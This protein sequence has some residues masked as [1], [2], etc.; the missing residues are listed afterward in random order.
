[1]SERVNVFAAAESE[2]F[3]CREHDVHRKQRTGG[4][5]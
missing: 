4:G 1:M 3:G 5:M 2:Y